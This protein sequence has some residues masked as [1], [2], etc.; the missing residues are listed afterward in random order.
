MSELTYFLRTRWAISD[1]TLRYSWAILICCSN[2]AMDSLE[3]GHGASGWKHRDWSVINTPMKIKDQHKVVMWNVNHI[4]QNQ[5]DLCLESWPSHTQ[6]STS[7]I[8][9]NINSS[10]MHEWSTIVYFHPTCNWWSNFRKA[11]EMELSK[12]LVAY[13]TQTQ[14]DRQMTKHMRNAT[15]SW[16]KAWCHWAF[17]LSLALC[18]WGGPTQLYW[19]WLLPRMPYLPGGL[20]VILNSDWPVVVT[21]LVQ[22]LGL[23]ECPGWLSM[24]DTL[25]RPVRNVA[26]WGE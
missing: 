9:M 23:W 26:V 8:H 15:H 18:C 5:N 17:S 11:M 7:T 13:D 14:R 19:I 3:F 24:L 25:D 21:V 2:T 4:K 22:W 20:K 12:P 16:T 10:I 6:Q 1:W